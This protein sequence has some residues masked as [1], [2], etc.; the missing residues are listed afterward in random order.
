MSRPKSA[1]PVAPRSTALFLVL[2]AAC[3]SAGSGPVPGAAPRAAASAGVVDSF[4]LPSLAL[5]ETLTV[6]VHLPRGYAPG[7]RYPA[8]YALQ[9]GVFFDR[10]NMPAWMDS[11]AGAG[12][13]PALA[14]A[15]PDAEGLDAFRPDGARG[16][17]YVRFVAD[18]LV[19]AVEARYAARREPAGR[20]LLGF[21]VGANVLVDVAARYPG[22]F[23]RVA[24][25]SPG[26]MFR[27]DDGGIGQDFHAA[28]IRNI[29]G[30]PSLRATAFWFAWG[31]GPSEWER[32]SVKSGAVVMAALRERG[33]SVED[34]GLLPGDH[35]LALAR[36]GMGP[37]LAFLLAPGRPVRSA[38]R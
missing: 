24:A 29:A 12:L 10:L 33:A 23:G 31:D 13:P 20:L 27:A 32:R 26:W 30:A 16:D 14:V 17:A 11:A 36:T 34:G 21:S 3:T 38:S 1:A 9:A 15:I 18:E 22:R 35:G 2:L 4:A 19:A 7:R 5:G 6:R 28:A 37:A 25:T 8:V